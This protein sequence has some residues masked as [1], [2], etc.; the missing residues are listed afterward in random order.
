VFRRLCLVAVVSSIALSACGSDTDV[1]S[2]TKKIEITL[3]DKGCTP[4]NMALAA[5]K[6]LFNVTNNGSSA[7]T[8]FEI[9]QD[10]KIVKEVE[11]I[12]PNSTSGFIIRLNKGTYQTECPHGTDFEDGTITVN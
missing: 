4:R 1:D 9:K 10:G 2:S 11:N 5:N 3:S 8:E 7:V 6:Y 12:I